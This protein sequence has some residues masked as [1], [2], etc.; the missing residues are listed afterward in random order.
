MRRVPVQPQMPSGWTEVVPEQLNTEQLKEWVLRL[1]AC[2]LS[3]RMVASYLKI[4]QP[5]VHKIRKQAGQP[6]R[7]SR[8]KPLPP[9]PEE[10]Q[11]AEEEPVPMSAAAPPPAAGTPALAVPRLDPYADPGLLYRQANSAYQQALLRFELN[12]RLYDLE[13]EAARKP[14]ERQYEM[15]QLMRKCGRLL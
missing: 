2:G 12:A 14:E 10:E 11:P 5:Y 3:Q 13:Q 7:V 15:R 4:S 9:P 8:A 6:Q 1:L